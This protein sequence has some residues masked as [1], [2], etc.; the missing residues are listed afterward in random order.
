MDHLRYQSD[1]LLLVVDRLDAQTQILDILRNQIVVDRIAAANALILVRTTDKVEL[2][3]QKP[4]LPRNIGLPIKLLV[5]KVLAENGAFY[6]IPPD[7]WTALNLS[8]QAPVKKQSAS[9]NAA[10]IKDFSFYKGKLNQRQELEPSFSWQSASVDRFSWDTDEADSYVLEE[11]A[12]LTPFGDT[13]L[14]AKVAGVFPFVHSLRIEHKRLD[15]LSKLNSQFEPINVTISSEGDIQ[16]MRLRAA[17][18]GP[19]ESS[20]A[21][22]ITNIARA[23]EEDL[24]AGAIDAILTLQI[25]DPE[26]FSEALGAGELAG[27]IQMQGAFT[28]LKVKP[29]VVLSLESYIDHGTEDGKSKSLLPPNSTLNLLG[30]IAISPEQISAEPLLVKGYKGSSP[31]ENHQATDVSITGKLPLPSSKQSLSLDAAWKHVSWPLLADSKDKLIDFP[32]GSL[33]LTGDLTSLAF[34]LDTMANIGSLGADPAQKEKGLKSVADIGTISASGTLSNTNDAMIVQLDSVKANVPYSQQY[35]ER[36][37]VEK[38]TKNF[39]A[40]GKASLHFPSSAAAQSRSKSPNSQFTLSFDDLLLPYQQKGLQLSGSTSS[41]LSVGEAMISISEFSATAQ[42]RLGDESILAALSFAGELNKQNLASSQ[43]TTNEINATVGDNRIFGSITLKDRLIDLNLDSEIND[44]E[45]LLANAKGNASASVLVA[46]D[47]FR[48]EVNANVRAKNFEFQSIDLKELVISANSEALPLSYLIPALQVSGSQTSQLLPLDTDLNLDLMA[49]TL[50]FGETKLD[51]VNTSLTGTLGAHRLA[52]S[53]ESSEIDSQMMISGAAS[54]TVENSSLIDYRLNV[55]TFDLD[56]RSLSSLSLA[57]G[58]AVNLRFDE[59]SRTLERATVNSTC[60]TILAKNVDEDSSNSK[61]LVEN[62]RLCLDVN[63]TGTAVQANYSLDE[64]G[65]G[66]F[67]YFFPAGVEIEG[68][69]TSQGKFESRLKDSVWGLPTFEA[70]VSTQPAKFEL[71]IDNDNQTV[72]EKKSWFDRIIP[73]RDDGKTKKQAYVRYQLGASTFKFDLNQGNF[74]ASGRL[75]I[76]SIETLEG[77]DT[78]DSGLELSLKGNSKGDDSESSIQGFLN[79]DLKE[80]EPL[81]SLLP[82]IEPVLDSKQPH[83]EVASG[84]TSA[85]RSSLINGRINVSGSL[86]SPILDG[87]VRLKDLDFRIPEAGIDVRNMVGKLS[88][89]R[90]GRL[91]YKLAGFSRS[92]SLPRGDQKKNRAFKIV[93]ITGGEIAITGSANYG[94]SGVGGLSNTL[95]ADMAIRGEKFLAVNNSDAIVYISPEIDIALADKQ[96]DIQGKITVP[97]AYITPRQLPP[98]A[99][100]ASDDQIIV[101]EQGELDSLTG[102]TYAINSRVELVLGDKVKVEAF[103]F[104]GRI[105]GALLTKMQPEEELTGQGEF[106]VVDGEYRAY[107]QGL[108][109]KKGRVLFNGPLS[110]PAIDLRATRRPADNILV[111]ITATGS[112]TKPDV[113]IFSEPSMGRTEQLSWLV[114]GRPLENSSEGE[115]NVLSQLALSYALNAGDSVVKTIGSAFGAD[116][117]AIETGSAEAGT[118]QDNNQAAVVL[119]KY[120]SPKLYISYGLGLFDA[121]NTVRVRYTLNKYWKLAATSSGEGSGGDVIYQLSR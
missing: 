82:M 104:S 38:G 47:I 85:D 42:G 115:S 16:T 73:D 66:H 54:R 112:A 26:Y 51:K 121:V 107:G 65:F 105:E 33:N 2:Q 5:E 49:D 37:G 110:K 75:P 19:I 89:T 71:I 53:A 102:D 29:D 100:R 24:S 18:Q 87:E 17:S 31:N 101:N 117:V 58:G 61:D 69:L 44:P 45:L 15:L 99:V 22:S 79:I 70:T 25:D 95:Q 27:E 72:V 7:Q 57:Q 76:D 111:G 68:A 59:T 106:N 48:P 56:P 113:N 46:G 11:A 21:A 119:G 67:R 28:N 1:G 8:E 34:R 6:S 90:D 20:L 40:T 10:G 50:T 12:I 96:I 41:E 14:G 35:R 63:Y 78:I 52:V 86:E 55:K 3:Q 77:L 109:V 118:A 94:A 83:K 4:A 30:Q 9:G 74:T 39:L 120:L 80:I 32:Q 81:F 103:G 91:E 92:E 98:G 116:T 43:I 114:L 88:A 108:V 84:S 64:L 36:L 62:A 60:L 13:S 93:P 97:E 23:I